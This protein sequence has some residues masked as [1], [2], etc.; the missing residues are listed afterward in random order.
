MIAYAKAHGCDVV[1]LDDL[2]A[3]TLAERVGLSVVGTLGVLLLAKKRAL[4][5]SVRPLLDAV[6]DQG[7]RLG[8]AMYRDVLR[9][10]EEV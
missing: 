6:L 1:G 4:I 7:F 3:R 10:A 9:L 8:S 2:Q 5:A